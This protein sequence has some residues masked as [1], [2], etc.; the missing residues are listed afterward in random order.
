MDWSTRM[1]PLEP[2]LRRSRELTHLYFPKL[3]QAI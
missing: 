1:P 3:T 2:I